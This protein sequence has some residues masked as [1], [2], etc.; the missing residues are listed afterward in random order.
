[1]NAPQAPLDD[2]RLSALREA[3]GAAHVLHGQQLDASLQARH[4]RDWRGRYQGQCLAIVS[5]GSTKETQHIVR[6]CAAW[7]WPIVPQGGNTSLVGG[8]VPDGSGQQV[9]LHLGRL[10]KVRHLDA[11][12][13]T[14]TVEA[15]CTL[16]HARQHAADAGML[17]PLSLAS[18]G[19]CTIGGT[20]ATNA[21]GTQVL[22]YGTAR[23][24]CLGLE[25]VT[26][27]GACWSELSGLRKNNTGYD[28]RDLF[29]GSEGTLGIIT[30][31]TLKLFPAPQ[32]CGTAL[33]SCPDAQSAVALL[34][35][36]RQTLDAGL[37]AFEAIESQALQL[38]QQHLPHM[39]RAWPSA[40]ATTGAASP[41]LILMEHQ[42]PQDQTHIDGELGR[43]M[44]HAQAKGLLTE[45]IMAH[46]VAQRQAMWQLRESIPLAEK[47]EGLMVKHDIGLPTSAIPSWLAQCGTALRARWPDCRIVCFGHLGD[48]NLHYNVQPPQTLRSGPPWARFENDVNDIVFDLVQAHG[49]TISAEHGI[50]ALRREALAARAPAEALPL[51]RAIKQAL[52]PACLLNPGRLLA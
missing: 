22:R 11:H 24:L 47:T 38:V 46:T 14:L 4:L 12:N 32:G 23:E 31:A 37:V 43:L 48:G 17:Y 51:M 30:A 40:S 26:A 28:L 49:G 29:I 27:S 20:L 5:P 36:A 18:G 33:L 34:S 7:G 25:V 6:L 21:G 45:A 42:G 35:L 2:A 44:A 52:D 10:N 41:W 16:D 39:A 3:V 50:G 15:G 8:S 9:L 13:F 1:M 19:Q